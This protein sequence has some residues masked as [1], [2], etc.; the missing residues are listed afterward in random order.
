MN[1]E[2]IIGLI[3]MLIIIGIMVYIAIYI[4]R[5]PKDPCKLCE[6]IYNQTCVPLKW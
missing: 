2:Q 4:S 3:I 1:T 6:A 5:L